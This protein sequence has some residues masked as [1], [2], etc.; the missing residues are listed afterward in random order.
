MTKGTIQEAKKG[1]HIHPSDILAFGRLAIDVAAGLTDL[2]EAMH[3]T[4][5]DGPGKSANAK[6]GHTGGITGMVY[7]GVRESAR[8]LSSGVGVA[9][10]QLSPLLPGLDSSPEREAMLGILNGVVG[11]H[12]AASGNPL[13]ITIRF[14]RDGRALVLEKQALAA[15]IPQATGRI[16]VLVH[17]LCMN[18]LKWKRKEHDHGAALARDM[19]YTPVYLHYNSGLHTSTNG[20]AFADLLDNLVAQWPHPVEELVI[21]GHSMGGLVTRGA[22]HYGA[23]AGHDWLQRLRKIVFV[24]T[25]HHGAPLERIGNWVGIIQEA[26]P[27]VAPFARLG[28]V[29]S[30][31]ITDLRHGNLIDEDWEGL[32][33]FKHPHDNRKPVPLPEGV[34]CYA[35]ATTVGKAPGDISGELIG[36]GLV[37]FDSAL[38]RHKDTARTLP[39]PKSRQWLGYDIGHLEQLNHPEV[40]DQIRHWLSL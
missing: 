3:Q 37:Q 25:P 23:I 22:C 30:A 33:R 4:I 29:R 31:G 14:R 11:D 13:A 17:G 9:L 1:N 16:A 28:K 39:F 32:D 15:A 20:R 6:A 8:L 18:D 36:D 7:Q 26:T 40:Y 10:T 35:I 38:G 21:I 34:E 12:L 5:A 2:V 24:G 19:G 27:Y